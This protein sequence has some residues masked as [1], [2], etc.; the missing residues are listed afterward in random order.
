MWNRCIVAVHKDTETVH[1][2]LVYSKTDL[3]G[4][5][6]TAHWKNMVRENYHQYSK[7]V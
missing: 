1:V 7:M 2:L 3:R 6:E 4:G 5:N